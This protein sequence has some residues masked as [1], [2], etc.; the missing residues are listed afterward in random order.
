MRDRSRRPAW[1]ATVGRWLLAASVAGAALAVGTV[2]TATLCVVTVFLAAAAALTWWHAD[3]EPLRPR[4]AATLLLVT[5]I[6][7]TAYTALQC[8][9]LPI[10]WLAVVA[11]RNADIWSRVLAPLREAGPSWA[12]IS[13]DPTATR[14]EALKGVAYLLAFATALRLARTRDGIA[15]LS[16][17]IVVTGAALAAAALLHPAFGAQKLY[18]IWGPSAEVLAYK[19][20]VAPFLNPNNLAAYLNVAFCLALAA[21]LAPDPRWPRPILAAATLFLAST[22]VWVASRGGVGTLVLGAALVVF[23]SRA[24]W[25][26]RPE[27]RV[28]TGASLLV[29]LALAA[30]AFMLILG[31]SDQTSSEL[32]ETNLSKF[33]LAR[34]A[35]R[36]IPAYPIFGAGR[37][38][39]ESTFPAFRDSPG[40]WTF[41]HPENVVEQWLIEWGIPFG[42]GG[43][44]AIV[45]GLRPNTVLARSSTAAGAWAAIVAVAVQNL[46][47]L[48]SEI[49]G[50]VLAPVVCAAIVVGGT[51]GRESR[52]RLNRWSR[53]P[54]AVAATAVI[55]ASCAIAGALFG[56]S[57]ELHDDRGALYDA[58][59]AAR[60]STEEMHQLARAAMLR[61]P[62]EPYLPFMMGWHAAR[63]RGEDPIAWIEA[64]LE[65]AQVYGPAHLVLARV[66]AGRALAQAR[67][68]YRLAI[69]Q[70]PELAWVAIG[71]A[72]R[73]VTGYYDAMELVPA[74][75]SDVSMMGA[76]VD[77]LGARLPATCARLNAEIELRAPTD[78]GPFLVAAR[79]SVEDLDAGEGAPWC[80]GPARG[81]C[82]KAAL[83]SAAR[84]ERLAPATCE[85]YV[86]HARASIADANVAKGLAELADA[87]DNVRE[88]VPCLEELATLADEAHDETRAAAA[89]AKIAASG[90]TDDVECA[91][92][93]AW[94]AS[95]EEH[96]GNSRRAFTFYKRAYGRSPDNDAFLE[97]AARMAA[98]SGLHTEAEDDYRRLARKHPDQPSWRSAAEQQHDA[99]L[100]AAAD[101]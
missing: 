21:T 91:R 12:P 10:T 27:R 73:L 90:C 97:A 22:Q 86:L 28:L 30:G 20:H 74:G 100:K 67:L 82:V 83:D 68:E 55:A 94:I 65:R 42:L 69:E 98:S 61:H 40:I 17:V 32:L 88:R 13:L 9:P 60:G 66:L 26:K 33:D 76:L 52:W 93:L 85:P 2:H 87:A 96:K 8:V 24:P 49:P 95:V 71:E 46:V 16:N 31:T 64:T 54:R 99:A 56:I 45:I 75:R 14:I 25:L 78:P 23:I 70:G 51:A 15:F 62:A 50:L 63:Q 57:G 18:G 6:A 5:G 34:Q 19:R 77:A 4:A 41:T 72:S 38:A 58:A 39:F 3:A 89:L 92:N 48:G 81:G 7:L 101:L 47:D 59:S 1:G 43:M 36:M 44:V 84:A 37:G 79:S 11:P 35:I 80:W 53:S 29:G